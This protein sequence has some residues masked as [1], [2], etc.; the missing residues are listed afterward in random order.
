MKIKEYYYKLKSVAGLS[1]SLAKAK[2]KLRN[3]GSYL[4]I[5]WYLLNPLAMFLIFLFLRNIVNQGA[6]LY[7]PIY[8]LLGLIIFNLFRSA[9]ETATNCIN[10]NAGIIKSLKVNLEPFVI[11][12]VMQSVFSHFFEIA[13]LLLFL[14]YFKVSLIGI[15]FYPL[16]LLTFIIFILGVSFILAT[17]G[18]YANDISNIWHIVVNLMLF[19]APVFYYINENSALLINRLNPL[20]YY[21]TIARDVVIYHRIPNIQLILVS[22]IL[23][24]VSLIVG[25]IV[26]KR[27]KSKF[28]EIV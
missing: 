16:V 11:S 3:E 7:Y 19:S 18:A 23:S 25:L 4:G 9:T 12:S 24:L 2:F 14:I 27:Y 20:F 1:F 17:I 10:T 8:L 26:F 15:L 6:V 13:T 22:V 28:A 21:I 5:F